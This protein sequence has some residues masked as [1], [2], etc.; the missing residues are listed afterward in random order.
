MIIADILELPHPRGAFEFAI[1][2]AVLHHLSTPERRIEA[3]RAVLETLRPARG[4]GGE[5]GKALFYVWA[6]E[7]KNSR[8]GWGE[9]AE[10]DI[11]VPWVMKQN[12]GGDNVEDVK[13]FNRYYHLYKEG[14]LEKDIE[15]AG[16]VVVENG[17][18]RDNWWA[19]ARWKP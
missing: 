9:G 2:I 18:E 19:I 3:V 16:G 15:K 8:R 1:S 17:Y 12:D 14:E 6:L 7:Q 13:T 11:L 4:K 5:G 10:Q